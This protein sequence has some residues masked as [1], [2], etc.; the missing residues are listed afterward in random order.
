[1]RRNLYA[2]LMMSGMALSL[3]TMTTVTPA[4]AQ[5]GLS[6]LPVDQTRNQFS[7]AP[8]LEPAFKSVVFIQNGKLAEDGEVKPQAIGSGVVIDKAHG[9]ILTNS[10]VVANGTHFRIQL[11]DGR[12]MDAD[13][14]GKD[15]PTD[16]AVLKVQGSVPEEITIADSDKSRVGD[17]VFALGY[18]LGLEQTLTFGIISGLGRSTGD[19]GLFD[20]IQTDA[21][22]NSGNSGGALLDSQG[23]LIG[24][25]TSILS[26]SGGSIGI[27]F[28]VPSQ[29][30][31]QVAEQL[32]QYG[33]VRRG[34]I[35][36]TLDSVS[37]EDSDRVGINHWD[38][39]TVV[40][41][42]EGSP[43]EI[44]GL[45]VGDV[46]TGFNGRYVKSPRSLRTWIGV[47]EAGTP[48]EITYKRQDQAVSTLELQ[49]RLID[50]SP[51]AGLAA[52]GA[53]IRAISEG[54]NLPE[55]I[56]GVVISELEKHSP[57]YSAGLKI[58][59]VIVAINN[60]LAASQQV[61]DR[62]VSEAH[63]IVRMMVYREG[64]LMPF[65]I[66]S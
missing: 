4:S 8:V 53:G 38:G 24:I 5:L 34:A 49:A 46:I 66:T 45:R 19:Q 27:G 15:A 28:S 22:I 40:S 42:E 56:K 52:L 26:Q 16:I 50:P 39:A 30:A 1:M 48:L 12:W 51:V 13:L 18:P 25:N 17:I 57:A 9:L 64:K 7:F 31:M 36:V 58:G 29:V 10:H 35:G 37:E 41:V 3:T 63:G 59:D 33:T 6:P 21:A 47:S 60:E 20:F 65:D 14:I 32:A 11:S 2:F 54:D 44:A 23:H 61:C 55:R 62:L 43:A